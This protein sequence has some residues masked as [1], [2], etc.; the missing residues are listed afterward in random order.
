MNHTATALDGGDAVLFAG[1]ARYSGGGLFGLIKPKLKTVGS[2]EAFNGKTSVDAGKLAKPR[3]SHAAAAIT[4]EV[5][6]IAGGHTVN[7]APVGELEAFNANTGV[8]NSAGSL[9]VARSNPSIAIHRDLALIVGGH[10]GARETSTVEAF[11][12]T[13]GALSRSSF[14][15]TTP[16]NACSVTQLKDGGV[17]VIGGMT[18]GRTSYKSLDGQA[19]GSAEVFVSH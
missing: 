17:V 5:V 14:R 12:V 16:R 18:G 8:W 4:A 7:G 9:R 1:G 15:L 3:L 19:I 6:L 10:T 11:N 2:A 13:T